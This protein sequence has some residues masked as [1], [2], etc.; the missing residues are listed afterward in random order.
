MWPT[1]HTL[2]LLLLGLV[3]L[4]YVGLLV[5]RGGPRELTSLRFA[6]IAL[7]WVGYHLSPWLTYLSGEP[8]DSFLLVSAYIDTGLLFSTLCMFAFL[9][10]YRLAMGQRQRRGRGPRFYLLRFPLIK[11]EWVVAVALLSLVTFVALVGGPGEAWAASHARGAGQ[12]LPR[13]AVGKARQMAIVL[14]GAGNAA[15]TTISALYLLQGRLSTTR[16]GIGASGLLTASLKGLYGFSRGAG[17]P[18]VVFGFLCLRLKGRRGILPAVLSVLLALYVAYVGLTQ[19]GSRNPG[20]GNFLSAVCESATTIGIGGTEYVASRAGGPLNPL[21]S[22]AAWTRK[23]QAVETEKPDRSRM[24]LYFLWNQNPLPSE[25]VPLKRT[26]EDLARVMGTW[27]SVGITTPALGVLYYVFGSMGF[28]L[29]VPL[30]CVYGWFEGL[31]VREPGV[32]SS[33]CLLLCLMSFGV[34]LHSSVRAMTRP[35]VYALAL[36]VVKRVWCWKNRRDMES[37]IVYG[38]RGVGRVRGGIACVLPQ[39]YGDGPRRRV[40]F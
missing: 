15:L 20:V 11:P 12:F 28:L 6:G 27:G 2:P 19:R 23:A 7:T 13:D 16:L 21:D 29:A 17:S 30:G 18:L 14:L 33:V 22:M 35:V 5:A 8:W 37:D 10:G 31:T 1:E 32:V 40:G 9:F 26:G 3:P 36:V 25:I 39:R 4:L 34:G 24:A 38:G